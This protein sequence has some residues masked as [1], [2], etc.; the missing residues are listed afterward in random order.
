MVSHLTP[1]LLVGFRTDWPCRKEAMET[2]GRGT[3]NRNA[4]VRGKPSSWS[5][6]LERILLNHCG[7][8]SKK[9]SGCWSGIFL[10]FPFYRTNQDFQEFSERARRKI[11][12]VNQRRTAGL[13]PA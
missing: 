4:T 12:K 9:K 1:K 5:G 11:G 6:S 2:A 7:L 10:D 8:E 13:A 3:Q